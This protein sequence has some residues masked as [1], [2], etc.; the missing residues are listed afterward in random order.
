MENHYLE[1]KTTKIVTLGR[2]YQPDQNAPDVNSGIL[3]TME[4]R[5]QRDQVS[6]FETESKTEYI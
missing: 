3:K 1:K 2:L 6:M 4:D 5:H